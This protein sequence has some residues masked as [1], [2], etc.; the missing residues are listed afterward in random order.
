MKK[1]PHQTVES[2][3]KVKILHYLSVI[4]RTQTKAKEYLDKVKFI[5]LFF[6]NLVYGFLL[7]VASTSWV[8]FER[9]VFDVFYRATGLKSN[10]LSQ[11]EQL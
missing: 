5:K 11:L 9:W 1:Q 10:T 7:T 3:V 6:E 2:K 8:C 4:E